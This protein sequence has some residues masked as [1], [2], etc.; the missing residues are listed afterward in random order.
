M[1]FMAKT[2]MNTAT[3]RD[4]ALANSQGTLVNNPMS[5]FNDGSM[6]YMSS[7][8]PVRVFISEYL[9]LAG[10]I[11]I[12]LYGVYKYRQAKSE[13]EAN[14]KSGSTLNVSLVMA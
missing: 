10:A 8:S 5:G 6:N 13:V 2:T 11:V 7:I 4:L 3:F 9:F 14:E 1:K 12:L